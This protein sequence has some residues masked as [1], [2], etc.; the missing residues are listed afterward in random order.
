MALPEYEYNIKRFTTEMIM[1]N[2]KDV[3]NGDKITKHKGA[4]M[5]RKR[6]RIYALRWFAER[7]VAPCGYGWCLEYS[8]INPNLIR[9]LLNSYREK[10]GH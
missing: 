10:S 4:N 6:N 3:K 9:I 5:A 7:S 2:L 8:S 1:L